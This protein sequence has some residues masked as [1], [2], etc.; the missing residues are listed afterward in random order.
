MRVINL[1]P[2]N[3]ILT[4]L[5]VVLTW[6]PTSAPPSGNAW[7]YQ[8]ELVNTQTNEVKTLSTP[9]T[10]AI[11]NYLAPGNYKWRVKATA[12]PITIIEPHPP[13][14]GYFEQGDEWSEWATFTYTTTTTTTTTTTQEG[15]KKY[16][17]F[18]VIAGVV[19][20]FLFKKKK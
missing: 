13:V 14:E 10:R 1:Q 3:A 2:N 19:L 17:P 5:P 11:F 12:R 16:L 8:V 18:I 4:S 6:Q 7:W 9:S 20:F 15:I